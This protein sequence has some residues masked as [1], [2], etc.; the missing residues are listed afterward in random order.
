VESPD[1]VSFGEQDIDA[2]LEIS[3]M[4][5]GFAGEVGDDPA[6]VLVITVRARLIGVPDNG[7]LWNVEQV[8][9]ESAE[10]AFSLWTLGDYD[11]LQ[12]E[13]DDGLESLASQISEA[14]FGAPAT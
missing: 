7:V 13:I 11:L 1:Y 6:L 8:T 10:A 3:L 9:Y 2:V 5:L 4:H 12:A 14:L